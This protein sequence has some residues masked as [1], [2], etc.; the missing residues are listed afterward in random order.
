MSLPDNPLFP[1]LVGDASTLSASASQPRPDDLRYTLSLA[2][3][4]ARHSRNKQATLRAQ[5]RLESGHRRSGLGLALDRFLEA[6]DDTLAARILDGIA[7]GA[8]FVVRQVMSLNE[9]TM[10]QGARMA[11][12]GRR[13]ENRWV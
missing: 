1:R 3:L 7:N 4:E 12:H 8:R 11:G 2:L 13:C 9:G 6:R 5:L 10:G